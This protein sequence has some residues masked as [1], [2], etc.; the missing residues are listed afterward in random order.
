MGT[1][2]ESEGEMDPSGNGF[3]VKM[4]TRVRATIKAV[5]NLMISLP[6][7]GICTLPPFK[8]FAFKL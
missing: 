4:N 2:E 7:E 3:D 8:A 5:K 1:S 6:F